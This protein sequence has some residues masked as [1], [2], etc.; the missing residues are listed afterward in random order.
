M[1]KALTK[2]RNDKGFTLVELIVVIAILAVLMAILVPQYI[3][4]VERS[5]Q[6]TDASGLGEI[7]HAC[8]TEAALNTAPESVTV[9]IVAND[10]KFYASVKPAT[11]GNSAAFETA[12]N[13]I[14]G[15]NGALMQSSAMSQAMELKITITPATGAVVW[16]T[17]ADKTLAAQFSKPTTAT[18]ATLI[19]ALTAGNAEKAS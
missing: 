10:S 2:K 18:S 14:I 4:Y 7:K 6:G 17:A 1:M 16:D 13:N 12:V 15:T 19:E 8:E 5:R 11:T 9:Q 3:Q